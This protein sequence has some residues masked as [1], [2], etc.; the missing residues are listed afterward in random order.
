LPIGF[1]LFHGFP[2]S[3]KECSKNLAVYPPQPEHAA[4]PNKALRTP[5]LT[6]FNVPIKDLENL[7]DK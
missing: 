3:K 2:N 5:L 7:D 4:G 1:A 6:F